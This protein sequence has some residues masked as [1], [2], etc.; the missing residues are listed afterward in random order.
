ME[1]RSRRDFACIESGR[2]HKDSLPAVPPA[3]RGE[4]VL[5]ANQATAV[6]G[7]FHEHVLGLSIVK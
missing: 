6:N 3:R 5:P 4:F 7:Y 2:R 1:S